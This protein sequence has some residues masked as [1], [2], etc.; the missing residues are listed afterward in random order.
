MPDYAY[1]LYSSRKFGPLRNTLAMLAELGFRQVEGFGDL[2]DNSGLAA[3]LGEAGLEMPTAHIDLE[4]IE[5]RPEI[6]I[7]RARELGIRQIHAP[8]LAPDER[9]ADSAGWRRLG[10]RLAAAGRPL[11]SAGLE[12]GWH[13]HDFEF[14]PCTDG[15]YPIDCMLEADEQLIL[16]LDIAWVQVAGADPLHWIDRLADRTGAVHVKD[17]APAGTCLDEDG[18][19][20]LGDGIMD[21]RCLLAAIDRTA[22]AWRVLEH[23]NPGDDRRFARR[24]LAAARRLQD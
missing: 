5:N 7:A 21:W 16:E 13:N 10:Q 22:C 8:F 24:S 20:D 3:A 4:T 23:D 19:A 9:P 2:L 17:I 1:Q 14:R 11:R 6:V 18:W 12:F 15:R